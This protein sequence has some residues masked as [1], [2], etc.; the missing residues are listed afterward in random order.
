MK[1]LLSA[2]AVF[3]C[4]G[5]AFALGLGEAEGRAV[6]GLPLQLTIPILGSQGDPAQ[7]AC[8]SL[9]AE[10]DDEGQGNIRIKVEGDRLHLSTARALNLPILQ[11][12]IRLGC[13]SPFERSFVILAEP[14]PSAVPVLPVRAEAPATVNGEAPSAAPKAVAETAVQRSIVL[15]SSTSLRMLSRQRYPGDSSIRVN[16]IRRVAAANPDL[17]ASEEVAFD[18]RLA[19]GTRLL[20]PPGLPAPQKLDSAATQAGGGSRSATRRETSA[21]SVGSKPKP[22]SGR[23]RGRLIIGA[24]GLA[25]AKGP[26]TAELNE[27]I[28]RLIEVMN[29]QIMVQIAMTER[30]KSVEA[31]LAELKRQVVAERQR[32]AQLESELKTVRESVERKDTIQLLLLILLAGMAGAGMLSW[33]SRRKAVAALSLAADGVDFP[34]GLSSRGATS[35]GVSPAPTPAPSSR[36]PPM[37]SAFDAVAD[38]RD[39]ILPPGTLR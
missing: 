28:D 9:Q 10:G 27:S 3:F 4:T 31:D 13:S 8:A 35:S 30:I 21:P 29:Q 37:P 6:I 16:F 1:Y 5:S 38:Q 12:R 22:E 36:T 2:L 7:T 20:L 39:D 14:A 34:G 25:A 26:S 23:G 15:M 32:T 11:F 18:Q 19:A 24:A 33:I 17:F